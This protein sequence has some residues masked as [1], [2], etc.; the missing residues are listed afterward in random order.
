MSLRVVGDVDD[1][2]DDDD[3]DDGNDIY[4]CISFPSVARCQAQDVLGLPV[5]LLLTPAADVSWL[6]YKNRRHS[7]LGRRRGRGGGVVCCVGGVLKY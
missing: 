7:I 2:G 3:V 6:L 4:C 1:V 5:T